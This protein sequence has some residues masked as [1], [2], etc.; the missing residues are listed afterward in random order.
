MED[1]MIGSKKFTGYKLLLD[2]SV[3]VS[4]TSLQL[5]AN[6]PNGTVL[7]LVTIRTMGITLR[8]NDPED[9]TP[10]AATAGANGHDY[11]V[12]STTDPYEFHM[13]SSD[14]KAARAI[15]NGASDAVLRVTYFG[16]R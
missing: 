9:A 5:F 11:A 15:R 8:F 16:L 3:T 13:A 4:S 7:A 1:E 14:L 6:A 2:E 10:N 12:N